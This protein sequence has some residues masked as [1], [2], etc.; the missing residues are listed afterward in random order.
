VNRVTFRR[1]IYRVTRSLLGI[2]LLS[3]YACQQPS[4]AKQKAQPQGDRASASA[5]ET[6]LTL[7][8]AILEQADDIGRSL[9]KIKAEKSIYS[10]DR[11]TANLENITGNL[12]QDG[13]IV[14]QISAKEGEVQKNGEVV[15]LKKDIIARDPRNNA[16][17]EGDEVEWH[18]KQN[19]LIIKKNLIGNHPNMVVSATEGKYNTR[20]E[21]LELQGK[22]V[23]TAKEQKLQLKTEELFWEVTKDKI[24]A[25]R[26]LQITRYQGQIVT[27]RINA[28][29]G[30]VTLKNNTAHLKQN[31][32]LKS[33]KPLTQIATNSL[34]WNYET[35]IAICNEPVR[36]VNSQDKITVTGN[37][38]EVDLQKEI[39]KFQGGV[40]GVSIENQSKL[41]SNNLTWKIKTQIVEAMGNVIY[42]RVN[43]KLNL[44]GDKAVGKLQDNSVVVTSNDRQRVI[45][46]IIP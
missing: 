41:Y 44:T 21:R 32:E 45:T 16:V 19:L 3:L 24:I 1:V 36:V 22:V 46:N 15:F 14:L 6:R 11:E 38:G 12:F 5:S 8:D 30:F 29:R 33:L 7:N 37:R 17:V 40:K 13:K 20:T 39:A 26:P 28:D 23:A 27:D 31:V 2:S 4:P 42:D 9:W 25:D 10:K 43:P 34:Q 35:R 18:P